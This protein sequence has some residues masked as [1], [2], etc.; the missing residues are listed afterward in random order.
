MY[1]P[2]KYKRPVYKNT[3]PRRQRGENYVRYRLRLSIKRNLF[4]KI[5]TKN[6]SNLLEPKYSFAYS[7]FNSVYTYT[8]KHKITQKQQ[9]IVLL[10]KRI[11]AKIHLNT[12]KKKY[13]F[14]N[15]SF[16][17]NC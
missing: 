1:R 9:Q 14:S 8:L 13:N 3:N 10:L 17:K 15:S 5:R 12:K 6:Y 7:N 16:Q 2:S 11:Q 4:L